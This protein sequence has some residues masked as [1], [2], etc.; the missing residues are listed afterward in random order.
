MLFKVMRILGFMCFAISFL[1]FVGAANNVY[2]LDVFVSQ[3]SQLGPENGITLAEF[4][5]L[6]GALVYFSYSLGFS[7]VGVVFT[8]LTKK[9]A[10]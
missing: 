3:H 7:F 2:L 6:T 1:C 4:E 10:R 9:F 8:A 5:K